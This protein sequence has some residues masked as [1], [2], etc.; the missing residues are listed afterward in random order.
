VVGANMGGKYFFKLLWRNI[1]GTFFG[2]FIGING[3][4]GVDPIENVG[5]LPFIWIGHLCT[6]PVSLT[7]GAGI[8]TIIDYSTRKSTPKEVVEKSLQIVENISDS[9]FGKIISMLNTASYKSQSSQKCIEV[10]KIKSIDN[11][12]KK[13]EVIS[14]LKNTNNNGKQLFQNLI[15]VIQDKE[16]VSEKGSGYSM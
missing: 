2:G 12:Q 1:K 4:I 7:L 8:K 13:D 15:A 9:E 11:K 5:I 14:Y 6:L 3:Q 16:E 10:C